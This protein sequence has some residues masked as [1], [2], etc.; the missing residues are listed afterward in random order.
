MP[1]T[2]RGGLSARARSRLEGNVNELQR[3]VD[4]VI[5]EPAGERVVEAVRARGRGIAYACSFVPEPLLSVRGLVPIR[6]RAPD[7]YGTP[8]ADTYLS[9]VLCPYVRA[10][11][12]VVLD[13]G[14]PHVDGWVLTSSCDAMRRLQDNLTYLVN[15]PFVHLVDIPHKRGAP[16]VDWFAKELRA[17]ASA[18][19]EHFEVDTGDASLRMAIDETNAFR[20]L[21]RTVS[22]L[23]KR[24]PSPVSG[25]FLHSLM[26]AAA[27]AP[28]AIFLDEL[29]R[30]VSEQGERRDA[31]KPRARVLLVGSQ[32]DDPRF[33]ALIESCGAQVVAD[34]FCNG[35]VPGLEP[36]DPGETPLRAL[37]EHIMRMTTCPRMMADFPLRLRQVLAL[38]RDFSVDGVIVETMKFC[39][40]WGVESTGLVDG[41]RESGWPVLRLER[42]Y[43][44]GGEGQIRTRVQAFLE[45]MDR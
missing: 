41:L 5:V 34:R 35:T 33:V 43:A 45:S 26:V 3:I 23:R 18:L 12:E 30:Y 24:V 6:L 13:Q 42:E 10:L 25:T 37:A 19:S 44:H 8:M 21:M 40:L 11:L 36:I 32:L 39:D 9:S 14:F 15:P 16:A 17:L 29:R 27:G 22:D 2:C 20:S 28:K 38:A 7:V 4:D 1:A 31:P